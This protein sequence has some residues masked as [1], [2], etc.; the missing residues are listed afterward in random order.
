MGKVPP[1]RDF[2][3][4]NWSELATFF[5]YP[6]EIRNLIYTTNPIESVNRCIKKVTKN[7]AIFP[8]EQ[9]VFKVIYLALREA[10]KKWTSRLRDWPMIYSQL[11][12][13]FEE[14]MEAYL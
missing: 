8:N 9:A 6:S 5:K 14:R 11:M 7:K 2:R 1:R 10:D 3:R 12:I 13:F 4:K